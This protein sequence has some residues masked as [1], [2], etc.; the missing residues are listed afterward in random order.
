VTHLA[1]V[2]VQGQTLEPQIRFDLDL[3]RGLGPGDLFLEAGEGGG[4][5]VKGG[6]ISGVIE[7]LGVAAGEGG[8]HG[9]GASDVVGVAGEAAGVVGDD[10]LRTG[11]GDQ[12]ADFLHQLV[13]VGG[14]EALIVII[15]LN[16][17]GR[18]KDRAGAHQ[19]GGA[20]AA[21]GLAADLEDVFRLGQVA[22]GQTGQM[23]AHARVVAHLEQGAPG[24]GLVVLVREHG[25]DVYLAVRA[26]F[27][28]REQVAL[29][30]GRPDRARQEKQ[31][32]ARHDLQLHAKAL[33]SSFSYS[34][35]AS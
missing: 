35:R 11:A 14:L 27:D 1:G 22:Q 3:E 19:L 15:P 20:D 24:I 4:R 26:R 13:A 23:K 25:K 5:V 2:L 29:R 10:E 16:D 6:G 32:G 7:A 30:H 8:E 33:I 18:A 28:P 34:V 31:Y 17:L 21:E 12:V 9:G